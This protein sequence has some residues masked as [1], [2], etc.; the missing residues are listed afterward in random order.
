MSLLPGAVRRARPRWRPSSAASLRHH[1]LSDP[2][3]AAEPGRRPSAARSSASPSSSSCS[4]P[5]P[6]TGA[7]ASWWQIDVLG[8]DEAFFGTLRQISSH[9][10][11][12][13]DVRPA[14]LDEPPARSRTWWSSC[15]ST[16]R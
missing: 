11:H 12:R 15:R 5:C 1:R 7:G 14:G 10:G 9:P 4:A 16:A 8:F 2:P 6:A 13:R 3:A